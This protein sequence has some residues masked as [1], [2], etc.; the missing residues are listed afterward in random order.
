LVFRKPAVRGW[1][2]ALVVSFV[3][4][5]TLLIPAA[6]QNSISGSAVWLADHKNLKR[7]DLGANQVDLTISLSDEAE[8][9]VVNPADSGVWALAKKKLFK[10]DNN[11]QYLLEVD[12]KSLVDKLDDPKH[13]VLN[14]YDASLWVGGEKV[15]LHVGA[16]GQRLDAWEV[17]DAIR[18]FALDVDESLWLLTHKKLLHL[19][20]QG[21]VLHD[22]DLISQIKDPEQLAIDSLG[23]LL[24]IVSKKEIFQLDVIRPDQPAR[25]ILLTPK[26]G[27]SEP[28]IQALLVEPLLGNLWVVTNENLLVIYDRGGNLLK[29]VDIG[30]HLLGEVQAMVFEPVSASYW[31]GGKKGVARFDS[32][33]T[34]IARISVDKDAKALAVAPFSLSPTL[35]LLE[36]ENDGVT[37]NPSPPIRLGLGASCNAVPCLLPAAYNQSLVLNVDLN[38]SP[39]GSL[40]NRSAT[41]ALYVSPTRLA[42]GVNFLNAQAVDLFGHPSNRISASFTIDTIPPRFITVNPADNSAV[43]AAAVTISGQ[44]DD[45]T[46]S[47]LLLDQAGSV[48]A[49]GGANFSFAVQLKA[50]LNTFTLIARDSAGNQ[51]SL[52]LRLNYNAISVSITSPAT[53]AILSRS[54]LVVRGNFQGPPNTGVTVNGE[55]AL[56][57]GNQFYANLNLAPGP[58]TLTAVATTPEGVS[59]SD[60]VTVNL[61]RD[62]P[63]PVQISA[64]PQSGVAPL[65]VRFRFDNF[66]GQT[67]QQIGADFNGDGS[68]DFST[69][70]PAAPVEF[71]Y[72]TPGV[73]H[74]TISVT[75]T[76]NTV[77]SQTLVVVVSD[78]VQM[79]T[80]FINL[81]NGMNEELV[82]GNVIGAMQYL[83]E[84]AKRKYQRVFSVLLPQMPQIIAS[85]SPLRRVSI[86]EF[87]GEYAVVRPFNNQKRLYLIYFL[88]DQDGVWRLDAM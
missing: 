65:K 3:S 63:D 74:A 17:T 37:N 59:A 87:I 21:A 62:S 66:S 13:L 5:T 14:P 12:I 32:M 7:I 51:A 16:L 86:S 72:S 24:W 64:E 52:P 80:L 23:G 25:M 58:N 50:G 84:N 88:K 69:N 6:A 78:A 8:A 35:K 31:I 33:G 9:L 55:V 29:T 57:S 47:V 48:I 36:P 44:V 42:E 71:T 45:P 83:N 85:Y 67:I 27:G 81:W 61:N 73:Y 49:M 38:G 68:N 43:T 56:V 18:D 79:D 60:S 20:R 11:G 22:Q 77:S 26:A 10:F 15:L 75:D 1:F 30:P 40:F 46:A 39:I 2:T 76:E 53:G 82:R 70:D 28:K 41:E 54:S 4:L 19:S 34:F